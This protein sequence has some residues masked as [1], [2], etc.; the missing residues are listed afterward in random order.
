MSWWR[1]IYSKIVWFQW[2][3]QFK[4]YPIYLKK[5]NCKG[6]KFFLKCEANRW[7]FVTHYEISSN[8]CVQMETVVPK[9][10]NK[11][12]FWEKSWDFI[13]FNMFQ[14][15]WYRSISNIKQTSL[16]VVVVHVLNMVHNSWWGVIHSLLQGIYVGKR[17]DEQTQGTWMTFSSRTTGR[18]LSS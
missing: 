16:V 8:I 18:T 15:L 10:P 7:Y 11:S 13:F 2:K 6:L 17:A 1:H 14:F 5:E 4:I 3:S 9:S 12:I